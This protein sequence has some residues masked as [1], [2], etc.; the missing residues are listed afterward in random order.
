MTLI[1]LVMQCTYVH[2]L[3]FLALLESYLCKFWYHYCLFGSVDNKDMSWPK[4]LIDFK[5]SDA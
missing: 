5:D 1:G 2:V 4:T 3:I